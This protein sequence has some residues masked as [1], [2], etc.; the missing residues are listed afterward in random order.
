MSTFYSILKGKVKAI[1]VSNASI[2]NPS[3]SSMG[4]FAF[5]NPEIS[6]SKIL[7]ASQCWLFNLVVY[8]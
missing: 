4:M 3:I 6:G 7:A 1:V 2:F 5:F 8:Q